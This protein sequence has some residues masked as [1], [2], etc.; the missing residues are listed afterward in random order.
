MQALELYDSG[1]NTKNSKELANESEKIYNKT[2][3]KIV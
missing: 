2:T 1:Y 3:L